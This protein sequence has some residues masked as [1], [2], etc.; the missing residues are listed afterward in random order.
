MSSFSRFEH[1]LQINTEE[2][3]GL[4]GC[5]NMHENCGRRWGVIEVSP[6]RLIRSSLL[7]QSSVSP[8]KVGCKY[9]AQGCVLMI[10]S[11]YTAHYFSYIL[12]SFS[13]RRG[14][15]GQQT[16]IPVPYIGINVAAV[17]SQQLRLLGPH[18]KEHYFLPEKHFS[19][20]NQ[21]LF[22]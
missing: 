19:S 14:L 16:P 10:S 6:C 15:W 20:C 7:R 22:L 2:I 21:C 12:N 1:Y 3:T 13:P 11:W 9:R 17:A 5:R 18:F 4:L 8:I